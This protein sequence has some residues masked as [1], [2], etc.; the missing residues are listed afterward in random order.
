M[1]ASPGGREYAL[2]AAF[3][4]NFCQFI[5]WPPRTFSSA[6]APIVIGIL[7]ANPFGSLLMETVDGEVVRGRSIRLEHYRRIE[8]ARN[9]QILFIPERDPA[10]LGR[11]FE[12]LSGTSVVTVGESEEFIVNGGM[13]ALTADQNRV[14]LRI[15]PAA[16]RAANVGMSS[17]LLRVANTR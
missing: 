12:A 4:Y 11:I 6:N 1:A 16:V 5:E 7:G 15:N 9:C 17:K 13:I 10:Q 14:R 2:K 3:L 8:D